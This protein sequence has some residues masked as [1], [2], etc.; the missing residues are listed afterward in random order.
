M[1]PQPIFIPSMFYI[2][3]AFCPLPFRFRWSIFPSY[4]EYS[5]FPRVLVSFCT[6]LHRISMNVKRVC[7][8]FR[9]YIYA[10]IMIYNQDEYT[11]IALNILWFC[12][13]FTF[14]SVT[15]KRART[16]SFA[17]VCHHSNCASF[18]SLHALF[19]HVL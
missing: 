4:T 15:G 11:R 17:L 5:F 7:T 2:L 14:D 6:S 9:R 16:R 8:E 19:C 1:I 12:C 3:A 18:L 10:K 13:W